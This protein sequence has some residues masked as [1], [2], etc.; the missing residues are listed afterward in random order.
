MKTFNE[1]HLIALP[2]ASS[3]QLDSLCNNGGQ[4]FMEQEIWKPVVGIDNYMV[5]SLGRVKSLSRTSKVGLYGQRFL[6]EIILKVTID[7][8]GYEMLCIGAYKIRK[9][10]GVHRI[11]A[12]AFIPNP[13]NKPQ[14]NHKNGI[15]N[16]NR[17]SNLEWVTNS[18]NK[19]HA[20]NIGM[21]ISPKSRLVLDQQTGVFY[22]SAAKAAKA[23][24]YN[25]CTLY[26]QLQ[27]LVSNRSQIIYV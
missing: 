9:P 11:V 8:D 14:V 26:S 5:S 22:D 12:I 4:S 2:L 3:S 16:D 21:T 23:K 20:Y 27:G 6:Q 13:E 1:S 24:G 19:K 15:K 25:K 17:L 10:T 18:E 7:K